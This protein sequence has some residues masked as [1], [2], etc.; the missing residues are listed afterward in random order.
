[1]GHSHLFIFI[2]IIFFLLFFLLFKMFSLNLDA[3]KTDEGG[4]EK[5]AVSYDEESNIHNDIEVTLVFPNEKTHVLNLKVGDTVQNIKKTMNDTLNIPYA[6]SSLL[7]DG[8]KMLDPLSLN[9]FKSIRNESKCRI[10][11]EVINS[12]NNNN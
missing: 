5:K 8:K 2:L 4:E 11:V 6:K 12:I 1:M 9:D 3:K 7:C 10:N